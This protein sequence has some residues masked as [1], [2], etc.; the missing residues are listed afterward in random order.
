MLHFIRE[1]EWSQLFYKAHCFNA[2]V[3]YFCHFPPQPILNLASRPLST[4]DE[5]R[6]GHATRAHALAAEAYCEE[7]L[8]G[9]SLNTV[10]HLCT[11]CCATVRRP[12][13][14]NI[15]YII[16]SDRSFDLF[17]QFFCSL[18]NPRKA[19][20]LDWCQALSLFLSSEFQQNSRCELKTFHQKI[21]AF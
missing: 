19:Y 5:S 13:V 6:M 17:L 10:L 14:V 1:Y 3:L 9:H 16:F 21:A 8:K 2:Y 18:S 11:L 15:M 12:P 20:F 4:S 7:R